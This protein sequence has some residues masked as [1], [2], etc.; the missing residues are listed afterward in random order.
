M[1]YDGIDF[2][3]LTTLLNDLHVYV[4]MHM[5]INVWRKVVDYSYSYSNHFLSTL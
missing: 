4:Y 1:I 2:F 5:F 3:W